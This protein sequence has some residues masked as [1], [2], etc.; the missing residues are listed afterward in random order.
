[1]KYVVIR[2]DKI[3]GKGEIKLLE[4]Y[5]DNLHIAEKYKEFR[6]DIAERNEMHRTVTFDVVE[7]SDA[8][9]QELQMKYSDFGCCPEINEI[10]K[11]IYV[12]EDDYYYMDSVIA[13]TV[14]ELEHNIDNAIAALKMYDDDEVKDLI[15]RLKKF[16]KRLKHDYDGEDLYSKL[17]WERLCKKI[18]T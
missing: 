4:G 18:L 1:M 11:G 8:K 5:S 3:P 9:F 6:E 16:N 15:K 13:E 12:S 2:Y 14:T 10:T 17:D 7:L